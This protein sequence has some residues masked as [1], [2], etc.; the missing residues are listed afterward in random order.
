MSAS[1]D[2]KERY[3]V[4]ESIAS[5]AHVDA[6]RFEEMSRKAG[7]DPEGFWGEVGKR[8][9]WIK[10]YSRVKDVSFSLDDLHIRWFDDGTLNV[11]A[12]CVDR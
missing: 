2:L 12:N 3:P 10:P 7:E 1:H 11:C 9:D 6:A 5:K 8:I 4:F